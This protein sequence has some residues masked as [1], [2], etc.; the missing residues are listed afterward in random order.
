[1]TEK[2]AR[3]L[4]R[5]AA[6]L[7]ASRLARVAVGTFSISLALATVVVALDRLF[8]F[9]VGWAIPLAVALAGGA[10]ATILIAARR[11]RTRIDAAIE[12]D[13]RYGWKERLSTLASLPDS[14]GDVPA[15]LAL[16]RDVESRLED[17]SAASIP[18]ALPRFAWA[19]VSMLAALF[20][21]SIWIQPLAETSSATTRVT[22]RQR[23]NDVIDQAAERLQRRIE[24][25]KL[26]LVE[27]PNDKLT[28]LL[29]D[30]EKATR[31]LRASMDLTP[32]DA[33]LQLSDLAQRIE[34]DLANDST[35]KLK[36]SLRRLSPSDSGP[37][38]LERALR[39]GEFEKAARQL[40]ALRKELAK[41]GGSP[42]TAEMLEPLGNFEK[43]LRKSAD[44]ARQVA[45]NSPSAEGNA[46]LDELAAKAKHHES[47]DK[48]A[49]A[50]GQIAK[51]ADSLNAQQRQGLTDLAEANHESLEQKL[52]EAEEFLRQLAE[53][54]AIRATMQDLLDDLE[55]ARSAIVQGE[56]SDGQ[57]EGEHELAGAVGGKGWGRGKGDLEGEKPDP[58]EDPRSKP[59][60]S[61]GSVEPG[62]S[63]VLGRIDG[64]NSAGDSQIEV[65]ESVAAAAVKAEE[66]MTRQPVPDP[67]KRH[68]REYF[69]RL[70]NPAAK[71]E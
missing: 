13:A 31:E 26:E 27:K 4:T 29:A 5:G 33:A 54:D 53:E 41:A 58:V 34:Q 35:E 9:G 62:E 12:I 8:A 46:E 1:M 44:L 68:T 25:R 37:A 40:E 42:E 45:E 50:I 51:S 52:V 14:M 48:L 17:T 66:A 70:R 6:R 24:D 16:A 10:A 65:K 43:E 22:S 71:E 39:E 61:P 64:P 23:E 36:E 3:V 69:E 56:P 63:I 67:Y 21:C 2:I 11:W 59:T 38:G 60:R 28:D 19:P 47:L 7:N 49:D 30:I 15:S 55:Q 32:D 18:I 20:A 57:G